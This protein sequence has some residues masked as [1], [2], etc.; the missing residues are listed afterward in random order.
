MFHSELNIYLNICMVTLHIVL[1][2][3][4]M[5]M[6]R[7]SVWINRL[8]CIYH[9]DTSQH[10]IMEICNSNQQK[11]PWLMSTSVAV[12]SMNDV[13][14]KM[15]LLDFRLHLT[16]VHCTCRAVRTKHNF[17]LS[18]DSH[19]LWIKSCFYWNFRDEF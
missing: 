7:T 1:P 10:F 14:T 6:H 12:V 19:Y 3:Q 17:T 13:L 5:Q 4:F 15:F 16:H 2:W 8:N 18:T 9:F 11:W